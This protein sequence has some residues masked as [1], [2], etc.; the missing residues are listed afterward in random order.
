MKPKTFSDT[1]GWEFRVD[2]VSANVFI[3]IASDTSG[4][5]IEKTGTDHDVLL[6]ECHHEA[7]Q[8]ASFVK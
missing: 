4:R 1:P 5:T 6:E 7:K 8:M 3:V 2:E